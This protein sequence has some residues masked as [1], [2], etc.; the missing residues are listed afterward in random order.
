MRHESSFTPCRDK[1]GIIMAKLSKR[2][3]A[4]TQ[5]G[6]YISCCEQRRRDAPRRTHSD[7]CGSESDDDYSYDTSKQLKTFRVNT[8][9]PVSEWVV[10]ENGV[11]LQRCRAQPRCTL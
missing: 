11:S 8:M 3:L 9:P 7:D 10:V 4:T 5:L 1:H 2:L 6:T